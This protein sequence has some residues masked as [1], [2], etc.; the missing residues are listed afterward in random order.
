ML[1]YGGCRRGF[2]CRTEDRFDLAEEPPIATRV[3]MSARFDNRH[4]TLGCQLHEHSTC[5]IVHILRSRVGGG[6]V[7]T[8]DLD[9]LE[10]YGQLMTFLGWRTASAGLQLDHRKHY[11]CEHD[12]GKWQRQ[13]AQRTYMNVFCTIV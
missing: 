5:H 12:E 4:L 3:K 11:A 9:A 1:D 7:I 10:E 13:P 8:H 6:R 2:H